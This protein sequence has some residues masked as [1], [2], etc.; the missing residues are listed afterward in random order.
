MFGPG[1]FACVTLVLALDLQ[2]VPLNSS[3]KYWSAQACEEIAWGWRKNRLK[4]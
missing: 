2:N 1:H 4:D 3:A